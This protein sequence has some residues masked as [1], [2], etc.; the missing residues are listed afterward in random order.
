MHNE[1]PWYKVVKGNDQL[2]QGDFIN[3]CPI[4]NP[5]NDTENDIIDISIMYYDVVVMSQSC[6]LE[7]EKIEYVVVCPVWPL[8]EFIKKELLYV[9][10]TTIKKLS[11]D[12]SFASINL[13]KLEEIKE[14]NFQEEKLKNRLEKLGYNAEE[15][16][17]I[18]GNSERKKILKKSDCK[19][20]SK[21][22]M[23]SYHLL[24]KVDIENF[25]NGELTHARV[26]EANI[27]ILSNK[28]IFYSSFLGQLLYIKERKSITIRILT[29]IEHIFGISFSTFLECTP[30]ELLVDFRYVYSVTFDLL[31]NLAASRAQRLRL[32]PPYR[33][34]LSQAFAKFFM[35]VGLPVPVKV[36]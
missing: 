19:Q 28:K 8:D 13:K 24:N 31:N 14:K 23:P 15:V 35:R 3:S 18:I 1:Y 5:L 2:M 33:E 16:K 11:K 32:L 20:I 36:D 17:K 29:I 7:A 30:C 25:K 22:Y 26:V 10:E 21:G 27:K 12:R 6:D 9:S 4:L 34:H